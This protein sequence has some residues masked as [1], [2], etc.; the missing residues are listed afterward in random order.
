L[1]R[2]VAVLIV[3]TGLLAPAAFSQGML[4]LTPTQNAG[5]LRGRV[6]EIFTF[7]CPA[8]EGQVGSVYG[9][10]EYTMDSAICAAAIH[11][12]VLEAGR[13]GLVWSERWALSRRPSTRCR[14][15]HTTELA[16]D[17]NCTYSSNGCHV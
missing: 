9:A 3:A 4:G 2:R 11:A 17:T 8:I 16:G 12:G 15:R 14:L 1:F 5:Q 7:V 13:A 6:G 10:D